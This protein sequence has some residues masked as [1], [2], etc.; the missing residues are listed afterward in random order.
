[1][2]RAFFIAFLFHIGLFHTL[3][4]STAEI[5]LVILK[6][7]STQYSKYFWNTWMNIN[8]N[9]TDPDLMQYCMVYFSEFLDWKMNFEFKG[10]SYN[11]EFANTLS[12]I[13]LFFVW[14]LYFYCLKCLNWRKFSSDWFLAQDITL[15]K[16]HSLIPIVHIC[17][18]L[19]LMN[20][21]EI[22]PIEKLIFKLPTQH[23][24]M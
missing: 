13:L 16:K 10:E 24:S 20:V 6:G 17:S 2:I 8:K 15:L 19:N 23:P 5:S 4:I 11:F 14:W 9:K 18:L 3:S 12:I 1:M 7:M 22:W 21:Q